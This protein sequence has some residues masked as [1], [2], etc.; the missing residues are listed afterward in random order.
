MYLIHGTD[1]RDLFG[2][3]LEVVKDGPDVDISLTYMEEPLHIHQLQRVDLQQ[4]STYGHDESDQ[5][6]DLGLA[7]PKLVNMLKHNIV[8]WSAKLPSAIKEKAEERQRQSQ[9]E[10]RQQD[11]SMI[12]SAAACDPLAVPPQQENRDAP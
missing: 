8:I 7:I 2:S 9:S 6:H 12:S 3:R 11:M 1:G 10:E 4:I 5:M